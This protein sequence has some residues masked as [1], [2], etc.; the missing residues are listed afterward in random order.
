VDE[1]LIVIRALELCQ[2]KDMA[3]D[4]GIFLG[5]DDIEG[6]GENAILV[7]HGE[8]ADIHQLGKGGLRHHGVLLGN[9]QVLFPLL[10]DVNTPAT[11]SNGADTLPVHTVPVRFKTMM[12]S[13]SRLEV[14]PFSFRLPVLSA[15]MFL[16]G[17]STSPLA[18]PGAC[19]FCP[20]RGSDRSG[21]P[22]QISPVPLK[23]F[24]NDL[25]FRAPLLQV[26]PLLSKA[27]ES[28]CPV[29]LIKLGKD[30]STFP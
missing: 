20:S 24:I 18:S 12:V 28:I 8:L 29:S 3:A 11:M 13:G 22:D 16:L 10:G 1:H 21:S 19:S 15:A 14:W 5:V 17:P 4:G 25:P 6:D 26:K 30:D 7:R 27:M 23:K 9:S 2:H